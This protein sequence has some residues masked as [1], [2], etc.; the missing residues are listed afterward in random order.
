MNTQVKTPPAARG[1]GISGNSS[2]AI[3][4]AYISAVQTLPYHWRAVYL[5]QNAQHIQSRPRP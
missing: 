3:I 1:S 4:T 5:P 2:S